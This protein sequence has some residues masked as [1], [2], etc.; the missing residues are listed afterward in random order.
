MS[1][2]NT[3]SNAPET[4]VS[5][6]AEHVLTSYPWENTANRVLAWKNTSSTRSE[7]LP[8]SAWTNAIKATGGVLGIGWYN[9]TVNTVTKCTFY[10]AITD[11]NNGWQTVTI[12]NEHIEHA[13]STPVYTVAGHQ[14]IRDK[15]DSDDVTATC[16]T[17]NEIKTHIDVTDRNTFPLQLAP[18][19]PINMFETSYKTEQ[20][21]NSVSTFTP[22]T[23]A[24]KHVIEHIPWQYPRDRFLAYNASHNPE[25]MI[26]NADKWVK[27]L[28]CSGGQVI[29]GWFDPDKNAIDQIT[30]YDT[31]DVDDEETGTMDFRYFKTKS[32][33]S[34][35]ESKYVIKET[36]HD[37]RLL[38]TVLSIHGLDKT[39]FER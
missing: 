13:A 24:A 11:S 33:M 37:S 31:L 32:S 36:L 29:I 12:N 27:L 23:D 28:K 30:Y 1:Y 21:W 38:P 20:H 5:S 7:S 26:P 39:E 18:R 3:P 14:S 25:T 4:R 9:H 2:S 6:A 15:L 17:V 8:L 22:V 10:N 19:R 35:K 34:G 16:I